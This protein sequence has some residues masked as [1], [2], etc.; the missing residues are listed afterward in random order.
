MIFS[1]KSLI[2]PFILVFV[3]ELSIWINMSIPNL[4]NQPLIF[5][6]YMI[7]SSI[8]LGATIDYAILLTGRY[9]DNRKSMNKKRAMMRSIVNSGNSILTSS[10]IMAS[11]GFILALISSVEGVSA[12]GSLIGRG[13]LLSALLVLIFLPQLLYF[14]DPWISKMTM[15]IKFWEGNGQKP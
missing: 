1:F 5:I 13:A 6:G 9:L 11:A 2:L 4:M 7:V 12:I 3:I 15:N 10:L 8:Q 14:F